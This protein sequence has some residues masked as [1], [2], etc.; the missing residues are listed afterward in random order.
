MLWNGEREVKLVTATEILGE[1]AF[2]LLALGIV[3]VVYWSIGRILLWI[4]SKGK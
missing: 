3:L 1:V 2:S 4:A